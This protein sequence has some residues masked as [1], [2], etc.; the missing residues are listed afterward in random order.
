[1]PPTVQTKN[2]FFQ[3]RQ[4]N[5]SSFLFKSNSLLVFFSTR[6]AWMQGQKK[7]LTLTIPLS[8]FILFVF[9]PIPFL[10]FTFF[11]F[12]LFL[13]FF[14][15]LLLFPSFLYL[16]FLLFF[17]FSFHFPPCFSFS[18]FF[19]FLN[20][21]SSLFTSALFTR[22]D[23]A[24]TSRFETTLLHFFSFREPFHNFFP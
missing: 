10:A 17:S 11:F 3:I 15:S 23:S 24:L 1:M 4:K 5:L 19:F 14:I 9:F 6:Q 8:L 7:I 13:S 20:C 2:G 21:G 12:F 18:I 22:N 16:F